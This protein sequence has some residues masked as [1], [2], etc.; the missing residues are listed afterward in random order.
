MRQHHAWPVIAG[1]DQ[2]PLESTGGQ[3]HGFG[4]DRP[5][6]MARLALG[7]GCSLWSLTRSSA[8]SVLLS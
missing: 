5:V 3:D 8:A 4:A 2:R 7:T 6:A 1:E